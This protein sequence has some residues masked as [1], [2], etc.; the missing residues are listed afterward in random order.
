MVEIGRDEVRGT[1][2][3]D[4]L[5]AVSGLRRFL[6]GIAIA[7]TCLATGIPA[8]AEQLQE[9]QKVVEQVSEGLGQVLR[10]DR[11]LLE[12]DPSFVHRLVDELFLPNVD[13][14]HVCAM[15]L[16]PYWKKAT[17]AQQDAFGAEFK[18]MLI[19]TYATAVNEFSEWEIRYLPLRLQP[20]DTDVLVRTQVLHPG[21]EPIDVD[22]RMHKNDGRWLAYDVKIAEV[23][24]LSNYRSTFA[25]I[26]RKKGIDGL[27]ADLAARNGMRGGQP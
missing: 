25:R 8:S 9:P 26:A 13:Y 1:R 22:Y 19:N 14:G 11:Q 17:P 18:A 10:E 20:G 7:L 6:Y 4:E 21:G 12:N 5:G 23:S 16:G 2:D 27:I 24:L 15:V 3:E